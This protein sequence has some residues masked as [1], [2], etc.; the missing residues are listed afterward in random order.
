MAHGEHK[1]QVSVLWTG[2]RGTGT[3]GYREYGLPSVCIM[4]HMK[5]A[6]PRTR[7]ISRSPASRPL[8]FR[9]REMPAVF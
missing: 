7:S 1:Y 5:N 9:Q 3:S 4:R 8:K 2:N 6:T